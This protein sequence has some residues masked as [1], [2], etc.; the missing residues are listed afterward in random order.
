MVIVRDSGLAG[1]QSSL[2]AHLSSSRFC[3]VEVT[4]A[5]AAIFE[6]VLRLCDRHFLFSAQTYKTIANVSLHF[7][8]GTDSIAYIILDIAIA[9]KCKKNIH[10]M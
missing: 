2:L 9:K 7:C 4:I 6:S 5:G 8:I 10:L 3:I 1:V